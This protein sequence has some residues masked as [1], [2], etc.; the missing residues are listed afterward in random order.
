MKKTF[1]T[2]QQAVQG[3]ASNGSSFPDNMNNGQNLFNNFKTKF[4]NKN[5]FFVAMM[6]FASVFFLTGC[7]HDDLVVEPALQNQS[8]LPGD[9][10]SKEQALKETLPVVQAFLNA[11]YDYLIGKDK[12]PRWNNYVQSGGDVLKKQIDE[13]KAN[14]YY[15]S[16][17]VPVAYTSEVIYNESGTNRFA[18]GIQSSLIKV[19]DTW[20]YKNIV[21]HFTLSQPVEGGPVKGTD[22]MEAGITYQNITMQKNNGSWKIITWEEHGFIG[23][24]NRWYAG[25]ERNEVNAE[26]EKK[27]SASAKA[28]ATTYNRTAAVMYAINHVNSPDSRYP[29]YSVAP[30]NGDCTNFVSQCLEAGGWTQTSKVNGRG[31][32]LSWYHDQGYTSAPAESKRSTS[33]TLASALAGY[34]GNTSRVASSTDPYTSMNIGDIIQLS[35][36]TDGIHHSMIVTSRSVTNGVT[37][38]KVHYRNGGGYPVGTNVNVATYFS[39]QTKKCWKIANS[40]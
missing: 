1:L 9:Q 16:F 22:I 12:N 8:S 6:L 5:V 15:S 32:V 14:I 27:L 29:D 24:E 26:Q 3:N 2:S 33:W 28:T 13:Y 38:I 11:Q 35:N 37:T 30:Y 25:R 7:N 23:Y 31:S 36:T 39:N 17:E 34:L 40:Y 21:D 4:M 18:D 10:L 20:V 19:G